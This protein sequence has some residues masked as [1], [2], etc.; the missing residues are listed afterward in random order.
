MGLVR[1][2]RA[3]TVRNSAA[4]A[5]CAELPFV[6][7]AASVNEGMKPSLATTSTEVSCADIP[8][9]RCGRT[10]SVDAAKGFGMNGGL[11][12]FSARAR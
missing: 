2:R 8:A 9:V 1:F 12:T 6:Y 4:A 5:S 3:K 10:V 7:V 11:P